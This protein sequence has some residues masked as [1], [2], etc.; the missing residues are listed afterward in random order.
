MKL[1]QLVPIHKASGP[2]VGTNFI[3]LA[4]LSRFRLKTEAESSLKKLYVLN[5]E[6]D[7]G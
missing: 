1:T 7:D 5:K 6:Q 3:D 2:E 4:Q